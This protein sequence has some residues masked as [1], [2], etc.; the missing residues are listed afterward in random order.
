MKYFLITANHGHVGSTMYL[1]IVIPVS[2]ETVEEAVVYARKRGGVKRDHADWC[3]SIP[4]EITHEQFVLELERYRQDPYFNKKTR[5][6]LEL[7]KDRLVKETKQREIYLKKEK[8][9]HKNGMFN[10]KLN[11]RK[12]RR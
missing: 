12:K 5:Q 4:V 10:I 8:A 3:L 11:V 2:A 7:F 9:F 6:R 1:P